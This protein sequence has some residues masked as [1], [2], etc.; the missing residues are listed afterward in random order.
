MMPWIRHG[1]WLNIAPTS[2]MGYPSLRALRMAISV[3]A[4]G[5]MCRLV[6][7]PYVLHS[8]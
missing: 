6:G 8:E 7:Y 4:I 3:P 5:L 1:A 2:S